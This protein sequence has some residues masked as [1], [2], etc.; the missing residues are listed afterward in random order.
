MCTIWKELW[1]KVIKRTLKGYYDVLM[2]LG[3][4][5]FSSRKAFISPRTANIYKFKIPKTSKL[6]IV[7]TVE[8]S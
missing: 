5:E 7:Q 2:A 8:V 3:R 6:T 4:I 1:G